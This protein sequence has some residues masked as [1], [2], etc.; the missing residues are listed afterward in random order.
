M[1]TTDQPGFPP[2][3]VNEELRRR[4]VH[5]KDRGATHRNY[6]VVVST[7]C[8]MASTDDL[9]DQYERLNAYGSNLT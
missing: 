8:Q 7:A 1:K 2:E 3:E 9:L 4:G 5:P 6:L